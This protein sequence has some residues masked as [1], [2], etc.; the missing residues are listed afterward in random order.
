MVKAKNSP[1]LDWKK[2]SP[3]FKTGGTVKD[4][5]HKVKNGAKP[6]DQD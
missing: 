4:K 5:K 3:C 1:P 2:N 6:A